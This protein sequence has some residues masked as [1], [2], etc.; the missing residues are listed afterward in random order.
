MGKPLVK[1]AKVVNEMDAAVEAKTE[2]KQPCHSD[3]MMQCVSFF[4]THEQT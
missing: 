3:W 2:S 1:L 4:S